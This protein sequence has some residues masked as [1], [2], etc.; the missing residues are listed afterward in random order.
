M[1][2]SNIENQISRI[3]RYNTFTQI[4]HK[5]IYFLTRKGACRRPRLPRESHRCR[6]QALSR[7]CHEAQRALPLLLLL[8]RLLLLLLPLLLLLRGSVLPRCSKMTSQKDDATASETASE[9]ASE[10]APQSRRCTQWRRSTPPPR[11]AGIPPPRIPLRA[12]Q[13]AW[14][15]SSRSRDRSRERTRLPHPGR[16]LLRPRR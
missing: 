11:V 8:L 12:L 2:E 5:Q 15:H 14:R 9:M 16:L 1:Q 10:M 7:L 13:A 4:N 3:I 6:H